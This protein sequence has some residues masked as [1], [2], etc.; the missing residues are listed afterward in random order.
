MRNSRNTYPYTALTSLIFLH[1]K[2][3]N[4]FLYWSLKRRRPT[5]PRVQYH[6]RWRA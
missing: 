5:L 3:S 6:R 4:T 1:K 2:S